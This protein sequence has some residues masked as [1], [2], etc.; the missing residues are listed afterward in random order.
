LQGK[1]GRHI[2]V[3]R[4]TLQSPSGFPAGAQWLEITGMAQVVEK[5]VGQRHSFARTALSI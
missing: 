5:H 4:P 3:A 2:P 1:I